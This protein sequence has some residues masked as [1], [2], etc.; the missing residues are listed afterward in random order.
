LYEQQLQNPAYA[1]LSAKHNISIFGT[2]DDH[3]YGCNNADS[4]FPHKQ[5]SARAFVDFLG[6]PADSAMRQ[7]AQAGLGVYGVQLFDF[8]RPKSQHLVP[9]E[10]AGI[11]PD[12]VPV[13]RSNK[14]KNG[15]NDEPSYSNHTVAVFVLDIR[16]NKSPWKTGLAAYQP[17]Y[18][19]DFLG[20]DQWAWFEQALA[21][22]QAAVHVV[23]SG[24]QVHA[25]RFPNA[26]VAE[27]WVK[28][29]AAQQRLYDALLNHDTA[30]PILISGDVHMSQLMRR[31]CVHNDDIVVSSDAAPIRHKRQRSLIELTTSGM[32]HSWGTMSGPALSSIDEDNHHGLFHLF[33]TFVARNTMRAMHYF[34]PWTDIMI[35]EEGD[36]GHSIHAQDGNQVGQSS[37]SSWTTPKLQYSL[38]KNFGEIEFDWDHETVTLRTIGEQRSTSSPPPILIEKK[39]HLDELRFLAGGGGS[40]QQHDDEHETFPAPGSLL[41]MKDFVDEAQSR[42]RAN[43]VP[44]DD[45]DWICVNHRGRQS[46]SPLRHFIG[47]ISTGIVMTTMVSTMGLLPLFLLMALIRRMIGTM[48]RQLHPTESSSKMLRSIPMHHRRSFP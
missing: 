44:H 32:T 19:G 26:N 16:S 9:E 24:V 45:S 14:Q 2:I 25:D 22:S 36:D 48:N 31:D 34:C 40:P 46:E 3:D 15:K 33:E 10:E 42:Q 37:S 20:E 7:R 12:I 6:L 13:Y 35:K 21:N 30:V 1:A 29:P 27:A 4:T 39:I 8:D 47:H 18:Q 23:V 41:T 5:E 17:D 28:F 43:K 38:E 11:D